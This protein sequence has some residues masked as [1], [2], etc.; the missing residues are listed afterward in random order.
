[1]T[2]ED[3]TSEIERK[4]FVR[5]A[6]IAETLG[7][8]K[9]SIKEL[10]HEALWE[11]AALNRNAAGTKFLAQ[12]YGVQKQELKTYFEARTKQERENGNLKVLSSRFDIA[13]GK[14]L[15]FEEWLEYYTKKWKDWR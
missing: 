3:L 11:M 15:T 8:S 7:I 14:Y 13:T 9:D 4:N 2:K 1:M 6:W 5:A 10:Q 12:E